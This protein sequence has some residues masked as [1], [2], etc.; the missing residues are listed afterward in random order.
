M[1]L[2]DEP[3]RLAAISPHLDDAVLGCGALLA[4]RPGSAV[5][6]VF[7]GSPQ[8]PAACT[9]WDR[10]CGFSDGAAAMRHRLEENRRALACLQAQGRELGFLDEQYATARPAAATLAGAL[11]EALDALRPRVVLIPL[12]LFHHDHLL[13]AD[14]SLA[15]MQAGAAREPTIAWAAYEDALYRDKPGLLQA[16]LAALHGR[17]IRATPAGDAPREAA[18]RKA[19]AASAY[20]S[21]LAPLGLAPGTDGLSAPERYWYLETRH[22]CNRVDI[23]H[24]PDLQP[25]Q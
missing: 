13:A 3:G 9:D 23:G 21:Q 4:A 16:R 1:K 20:A 18:A 10:R 2:L 25:P 8:D 11:S 15:L 22:D 6:T 7:A 5:I 14:A 17:G 19:Q 24:R 12:G